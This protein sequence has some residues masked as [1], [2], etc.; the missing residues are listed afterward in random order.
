MTGFASLLQ[1]RNATTGSTGHESLR[2]S[3]RLALVCS[4]FSPFLCFFMFAPISPLTVPFPAKLFSV[5]FFSFFPLTWLLC[6]VAQSTSWFRFHIFFWKSFL[7]PFKK[8][9]TEALQAPCRSLF[10]FM[11]GQNRIQNDP[12]AEA[13][14]IASRARGSF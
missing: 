2:L 13:H 6:D 8:K 11:S 3:H 5:V 14:P 12:I 9:P 4:H 10:L 1:D 7:S